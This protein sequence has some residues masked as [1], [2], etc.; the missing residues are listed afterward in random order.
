MIADQELQTLI[1][2]KGDRPV[3]TLYLD[4]DLT[5]QSKDAVKLTA[6][7][8]LKDYGKQAHREIQVIDKY[9]DFEYDWQSPGLAI[10]AS[11]GDLWQTIPLPVPV[12]PQAYYTERPYIRV[13][14]DVKDRLTPYV[15]ALLDSESLRLFEVTAGTIRT[16]SE[17]SG[18]EIKR[19][20]QGGWAAARFQR[21]E[22]NMAM[23][24]LKQA[25]QKIQDFLQETGCSRL[26]LAG[27]P[28]AMTQIKDLLPKPLLGQMIGE[29]AA[30]MEAT[31]KDLLT[32]SLDIVAQVDQAEEQRIVSEAVTAAAKG[33]A[34][35]IG[36]VDTLFALH[37]AQV[38]TLLIEEDYHAPGYV[39]GN[40]GFVLAEQVEKC[41]FCN[42]E[43]ISET[44]DAA[45]RAIE[46]A[47]KT[48]ADVNI[49]RDNEELDRA[50]GI[51]ATLRY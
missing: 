29:F 19:H 16:G 20:R 37:R 39:C 8:Q 4:T 35:V 23:H 22:D 43:A 11:G 27:N 50:G 26:I 10:F 13:L 36:L 24:N 7:Q 18:E 9:L 41:P 31:P 40:C 47:L 45:D 46:K 15:V 32:R 25:A 38:R 5:H 2:F 14:S 44:P 12:R 28:E 34:G 51:A 1:D 42:Q 6:R 48:G 30:D 17:T 49:V 3:L 33:G 21:H